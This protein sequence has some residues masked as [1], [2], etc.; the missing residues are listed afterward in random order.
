MLII[1]LELNISKIFRNIK[2]PNFLK[3]MKDEHNFDF[4][5]DK[6]QLYWGNKPHKLVVEVKKYLSQNSKILDLG[7]GEGQNANDFKGT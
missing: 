3:S 7:C 6:K 4:K 5:Y 2:Y 1:F